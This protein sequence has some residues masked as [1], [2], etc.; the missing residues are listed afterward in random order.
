MYTAKPTLVIYIHW[1]LASARR[2]SVPK[3]IFKIKN[4]KNKILTIIFK[5]LLNQ[6]IEDNDLITTELLLFIV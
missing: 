6:S 4:N 3:Y 1:R 5:V 2:D